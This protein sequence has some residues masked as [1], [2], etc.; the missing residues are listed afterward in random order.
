[1]SPAQVILHAALRSL[2]A[3]R[4]RGQGKLGLCLGVG[5]GGARQQQGRDLGIGRPGRRIRG[6]KRLGDDLEDRI[7]PFTRLG[8]VQPPGHSFT[9]TLGQRI[10]QALR[11]GPGGLPLDQQQ[12]PPPL[13]DQRQKL[14]HPDDPAAQ[15][16]PGREILRQK[17]GD[18]GRGPIQHHHGRILRSDIRDHANPRH[19][20]RQRRARQ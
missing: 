10:A 1:M 18:L 3:G 17:T 5:V 20:D 11:L 7:G 14:G 19:N 9:Q 4:S 2:L 13:P 16:G 8:Q 6:D 15:G 12:P